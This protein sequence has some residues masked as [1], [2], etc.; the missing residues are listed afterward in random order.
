MAL[1][2][3]SIPISHYCEKARWAL[4]CAG[5]DYEELCHV[6]LFHYGSTLWHGRSLYAPV[7]VT[8]HGPV[9]GSS[10]I[11]RYADAHAELPCALIPGNPVDALRVGEFEELF[12]RVV[13][14]EARRWMYWAGF[15]QLGYAKMLELAAQGTP[16]WEESIAG[17][18]M[19]LGR[20]YLE[21]RLR[22]DTTRVQRGM[23]ELRSVFELVGNELSDGRRYLVAEK[24][25]AAD[26]TFAALSAFVLMPPEYGVH[27]PNVDDLPDRMRNLVREFRATRAGE[28]ALRLYA[29]ERHLPA[30]HGQKH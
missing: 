16:P 6:Q 7:L 20:W 5:L 17:F 26:L 25:T 23:S 13:G 21:K 29:D 24:F 3:S 4:E 22:I 18:I 12:D 9:A 28:F 8:E 19:P 2:L 1:R 14:V 30:S 11:V 10:R 27:L 15:E